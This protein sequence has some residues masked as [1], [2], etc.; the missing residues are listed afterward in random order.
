MDG[1]CNTKHDFV[2]SNMSRDVWEEKEMG[3]GLRRMTRQ[4]C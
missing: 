3:K 2:G 4:G 1:T